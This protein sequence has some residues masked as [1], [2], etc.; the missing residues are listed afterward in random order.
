[1]TT[2]E[3]PQIMNLDGYKCQVI[4]KGKELT[5]CFTDLTLD[6]QRQYL[7]SITQEEITEL[8]ITF[9]SALR[10]LCEMFHITQFG[11]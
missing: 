3:Y 11:G 7:N 10:G 4:R 1:M 9:A 2:D 5:L 8:C 6:E